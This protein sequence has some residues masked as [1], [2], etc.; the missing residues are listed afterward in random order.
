MQLAALSAGLYDSF[1]NVKTKVDYLVF[2]GTALSTTGLIT[3]GVLVMVVKTYG[4]DD[5]I[6]KFLNSRQQL[7]TAL[8]A[9]CGF[10]GFVFAIQLATQMNKG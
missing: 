4:L 8:Q 6:A 5:V 10:F 3:S 7:F 2:V 1:G 9:I